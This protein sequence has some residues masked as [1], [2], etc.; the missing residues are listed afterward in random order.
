[1]A[2]LLALAVVVLHHEL[3]NFRYH[4]VRQALGGIPRGHVVLAL[5]LTA[6]AYAVLPGYDAL[7]LAYVGRRLGAGRIALASF[8]AYALSQTLGFPLLTG[9]AVRARFWNSWGLGA[10]EIAAA[11]GFAGA[12]FVLGLMLT[13]GL[14]LLLEPA[15]TTSLLPLP[16]L[17]VRALGV[18]LVAIVAGYVAWSVANRGPLRIGGRE[19][20]APRP[21]LALLQLL[22]AA[23]DWT[24]AAAVL[25]VLLPAPAPA[26]AGFLGVFLL[27][28]FAGLVSHV[29]GG[30]GVFDALVVLLLGPHIAAPQV[31]SA[32]IAYRLVYY[33]LP[34]GVG[35]TLLTATEVLAHARPRWPRMRTAVSNAA[36][37]SAQLATRWVPPLVPYL[38]GAAV[39][40]AGVILL[41]SGAT[42]SIHGRVAFLD[43]LLPLGVIELSHFVASVAGAMLMIL[44]WALTRRLDAAFAV[45]VVL[46]ALGIVASL[47]KGFDWEEALAL[48][49]VLLILVPSRRAFPRRSAL[50]A[51]PFSPEW[52]V[53]MV[54]VAGVSVWLGL[55]SYKHVG[56]STELFWQFATHGDAPRFVRA[57]VGVLV[58]L[59]AFGFH[60]LLGHAGAGWQV[61]SPDDVTRAVPIVQDSSDS[62]A[63]LALLDDKALLFDDA[64]S[65]LLMYGVAGRAWIAMGD[66]LGP[67]EV[68][69]ALA[70]QFRELAD[71]H[72]GWAAFY[73]VGTENLP[74]YIELGLSL[75][76]SG[77]E[78][79]V[80]L[81][82]F[83]LEGSGRRGLRR[84]QREL[85]KAGASFE[86][87]AAEAVPA[88]LGELRQVSD[89]WLTAKSTREKRFS[90]GRFDEAYLARF[91]MGVVRVGDRI[92][93]FANLWSGAR[94]AELSPD[95]MRYSAAAPKGV[96]EFLF[97]EL[98]LW[99]RDQGYRE[100]NLGVAP[101]AGLEN[102]RLAPLWSRAA[103]LLY[104]RGEPF[105]GFQG[106]RLFKDKFDPVWRPRY[107]AAPRGL[108]LPRVVA[109]ITALV[110]GGLRGA[111]AR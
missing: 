75:F 8:I 104:R 85:Q 97:I 108:G 47:L 111:F 10:G 20:R 5:L 88:L 80:S 26:F 71:A 89:D 87:V 22:V 51:E 30:L 15:G 110:S 6:A 105:Y 61:A 31:L 54:C 84:C 109:G 23:A 55:F 77:E 32:L 35:L 72:G 13:T 2:A 24:L 69:R 64:G 94:R 73:E 12:T 93:A 29:P 83:T 107:L 41:F 27:A 78:A 21:S 4:D 90:L 45:T 58:T 99:G 38:L 100:F 39:F 70:W 17:L 86:V 18:L 50:T 3:R 91:P 14:A 82:A 65:G 37:V 9:G 59:A 52:V 96:V 79:I 53:A 56:F 48:S 66:P 25:Y 106:L 57:T 19:L 46:L 76:K 74:L 60:R 49:I 36:G 102:R 62:M 1:M 98:M 7:A 81:P 40:A 34:F 43:D 95:L 63:N 67:P 33:L 28:Q 44:G 101:L 103:G 68:R 16:G 11:V 92:V 42:P